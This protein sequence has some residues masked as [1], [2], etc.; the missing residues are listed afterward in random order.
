VL[1]PVVDQSASHAQSAATITLKATDADND[2]PIFTAN[3]QGYSKA[4]NCSSK[5]GANEFRQQLLFNYY[6]SN[7]KWLQGP[8]ATSYCL[9][10]N[11]EVHGF[12]GHALPPP[13]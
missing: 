2:T 11:G 4:Y 3:V 1:T 7:E 8:S 5:W 13:C 9:L 6:G 10:A 12:T